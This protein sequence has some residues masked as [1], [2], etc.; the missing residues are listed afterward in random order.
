MDNVRPWMILSILLLSIFIFMFFVYVPS[1][2]PT[3]TNPQN[4][5]SENSTVKVQSNQ[6]VGGDGNHSDKSHLDANRFSLFHL[7]LGMSI[8]MFN[9]KAGNSTSEFFTEGESEPLLVLEYPDF[10]AGFDTMEKAEFITVTSNG[11]DVGL[12]GIAIG[13]SVEDVL[14]ILGQPES[15]GTY[16]IIYQKAGETL[17]FDIDPTSQTVIS[18]KLFKDL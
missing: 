16:V 5:T 12:G 3:A 17:K 6:T 4:I 15:L 1:K 14:T 2:P 7:Q 13:S 10:N 11:I 8:D 9:Q 18:I